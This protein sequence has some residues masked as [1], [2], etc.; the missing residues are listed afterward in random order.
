[1]EEQRRQEEENIK[2]Q[3]MDE[4]ERIEYLRV[5]EQEEEE[6]RKKEEENKRR[7]EEAALWGAEQARM[8]ARYIF[9]FFFLLTAIFLYNCL[10]NWFIFDK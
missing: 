1:M 10:L 6:R 9:T 5:K 7:E 3:G 4:S 2:L 8:L